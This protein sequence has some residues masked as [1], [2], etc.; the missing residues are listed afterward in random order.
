MSHKQRR[1]AMSKRPER[2]ADEFRSFR[3]NTLPSLVKGSLC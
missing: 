2:H 3:S 1:Q